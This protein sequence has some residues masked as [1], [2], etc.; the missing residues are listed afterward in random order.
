MDPSRFFNINVTPEEE[1]SELEHLKLPK[2]PALGT[3]E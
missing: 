2:L 3:I 1:R